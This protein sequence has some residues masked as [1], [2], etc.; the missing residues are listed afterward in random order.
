MNVVKITFVLYRIIF[1]KRIIV[2]IFQRNS[3]AFRLDAF[4]N[5]FSAFHTHSVNN[6]RIVAQIINNV[7]IFRHNKIA[8]IYITMVK[9]QIVFGIK[10]LNIAKQ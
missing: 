1:A 5:I 3:H 7:K 10:K 2:I 9:L 8:K 4:G 6:I